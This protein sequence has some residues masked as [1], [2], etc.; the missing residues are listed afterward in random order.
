MVH[1][2]SIP[3]EALVNVAEQVGNRITTLLDSELPLHTEI[4]LAE[5]FQVWMIGAE[6]ARLWRRTTD[7][8]DLVVPTNRWHHQIRFNG[9][10]AAFARSSPPDEDSDQWLL[11]ELFVSP[12]A[13]R[14]E[15]GIDR[16]DAIETRIPNNPVV[17]LL[18][19]PAYQAHAFWLLHEAE[20]TSQ[21]LVIDR[22]EGF[23]NLPT[24]RVLSSREFLAN[25]TGKRYVVGVSYNNDEA[26]QASTGSYHDHK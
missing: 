18:V 1:A 16:I 5:T 19:A 10:A 20:R 8:A 7:L 4:E 15:E 14:I 23:A 21:V 24:D 2:D 17:R 13:K 9:E 11:C 22:P 12:L 6:P 26:T 3:S 25:L